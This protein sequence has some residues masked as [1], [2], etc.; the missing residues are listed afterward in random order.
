MVLLSR[1]TYATPYLSTAWQ[2]LDHAAEALRGLP[3]RWGFQMGSLT[4]IVSPPTLLLVWLRFSLGNLLQR[5]LKETAVDHQPEFQESKVSFSL[6]LK[7]FKPS[8][9]MS[10]SCMCPI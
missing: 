8:R 1:T 7:T 4:G 5:R 3:W 10:A 9:G 2:A 6:R